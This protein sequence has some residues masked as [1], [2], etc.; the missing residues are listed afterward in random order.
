MDALIGI[1]D[2]EI[3]EEVENIDAME[4]YQEAMEEY[5]DIAPSPASE[6]HLDFSDWLSGA[7]RASQDVSLSQEF[8][9]VISFIDEHNHEIEL[10]VK[11]EWIPLVC[12]NCSGIGHDTQSCRKKES[13]EEQ[14][15]HVW[16]PK[17]S[18]ET[19]EIQKDKEGF[20]QVLKGKRV[21]MEQV[22]LDTA[23]QNRFGTLEF[24]WGARND[25]LWNQKQWQIRIIVDR[26]QQESKRRIVGIWPSKTKEKDKNWASITSKTNL[27]SK[28]FKLLE[29]KPQGTR[30]P[31]LWNRDSR[32]PKSEANHKKPKI[33]V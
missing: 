3:P 25:V 24:I 4:Q 27:N 8:P 17:K 29:L 1:Q 13:R 20:Q 7:N 26:V 15:K 6:I 32:E 12:Y 28:R 33:K 21:M 10:E 31:S 5:S 23:I 16:I 22:H 2:L 18:K 19:V 9:K 30:S 11:Y 14:V